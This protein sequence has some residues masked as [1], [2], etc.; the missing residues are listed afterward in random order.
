[1]CI[2]ETQVL[3]VLC[4]ECG[5]GD[6]CGQLSVW[7]QDVHGDAGLCHG[8]LVQGQHHRQGTLLGT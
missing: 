1:M 5:E 8:V 2:P 4:V 6:L 3:L 7:Q